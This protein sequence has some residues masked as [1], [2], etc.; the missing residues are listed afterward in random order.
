MPIGPMRRSWFENLDCDKPLLT[1][2]ESRDKFNVRGK[3]E[4]A[5]EPR[6]RRGRKWRRT[7]GREERGEGREK[8]FKGEALGW[9]EK[10]IVTE[11]EE[12]GGGVIEI[13]RVALARL[14]P[15]AMAVD[16]QWKTG[17]KASSEPVLDLRLSLFVIPGSLK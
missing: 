10:E 11:E 1:L 6:G 3:R 14:A 12:M 5:V 7:R 15:A 13:F 9:E 8:G 2:Q 4:E 16:V 17:K